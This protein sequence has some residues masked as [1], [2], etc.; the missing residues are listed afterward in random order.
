MVSSNLTVGRQSV[1]GVL[2]KRK[3]VRH[4]DR[5]DTDWLSKKTASPQLGLKDCRGEQNDKR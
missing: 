1:S 3:T 5:R 2:W 4:L